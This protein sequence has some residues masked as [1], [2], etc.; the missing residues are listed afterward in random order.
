MTNNLSGDEPRLSG[1]PDLSGR[2]PAIGGSTGTGLREALDGL[3][4]RDWQVRARSAKYLG[5][6]QVSGAAE[7]IVALFRD[8]NGQVRDAALRAAVRIGEPAVAPLIALL[9]ETEQ[10]KLIRTLILALSQIGE[11][12]LPLLIHTLRTDTEM[13]ERE[14]IQALGAIPHPTSTRALI[15]LLTHADYHVYGPAMRALR[16]R[17]HDITPVI[18][19]LQH[20]SD[21]VRGLAAVILG[22]RGDTLAVPA[23]IAAMHD[24]VS[25]VRRNV[26]GALGQLGNDEA[27]SALIETLQSPDATVR[28]HAASAIG[29]PSDPE[30]RSL[31]REILHSD[32]S[33][34]VRHAIFD[35]LMDHQSDDTI[36]ELAAVVQDTR[37]IDSMRFL[38]VQFLCEMPGARHALSLIAQDAMVPE[39][40]REIAREALERP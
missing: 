20:A 22:A 21:Q 19:A 25:D 30:I 37:Q 15:D 1:T 31:L 10:P 35:A 39:M 38:A 33:W 16:G 40:V 36:G 17:Q 14:L 24:P 3:T 23:L 34:E 12:A 32:P 13:D 4:S 26:I 2:E 11:P 9:R 28:T 7:R 6:Q 5:D 18:A 27:I 8:H 29:W